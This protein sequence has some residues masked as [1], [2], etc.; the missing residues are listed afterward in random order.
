MLSAQRRVQYGVTS[1]DEL[2]AALAATPPD[3]ILTG[4][5]AP[6]AGFGFQDKGGLETPLTDYAVQ[7][8]YQRIQLAPSF[9]EHP[10][11]LWVRPQ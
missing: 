11:I 1:P 6:N 7:H 8:D 9:L 10:I 5:E 2:P 4:F 3:A